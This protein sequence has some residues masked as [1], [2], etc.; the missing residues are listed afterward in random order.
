MFAPRAPAL[1]LLTARGGL[2]TAFQKKSKSARGAVNA[3]CPEALICVSSPL[4][5]TSSEFLLSSGRSGQNAK[6]RGRAAADQAATTTVAA[7]VS[8]HAPSQPAHHA[9]A[10]LR[11]L[12]DSRSRR[13]T[14]S[15]R[16]Q[17]CAAA[18]SHL[19]G[20]ADCPHCSVCSCFASA[21]R[22]R[23]RQPCLHHRDS[24]SPSLLA[25]SVH[26]TVVPPSRLDR[27]LCVCTLVSP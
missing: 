20:S 13:A 15:Q 2:E 12:A 5:A 3:L 27:I 11:E 8:S 24:T 10:P 18:T 16:Q 19:S 23:L 17:R 21:D 6:K 4:F 9:R 25:R 1:N 26:R 14:E 22:I 7:A